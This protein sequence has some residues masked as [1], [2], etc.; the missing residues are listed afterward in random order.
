MELLELAIRKAKDLGASEAVASYGLSRRLRVELE[1]NDVKRAN[2]TVSRSVRVTV[3][4]GK[5]LATAVTTVPTR[6]EVEAIVDKAFKIAVASRPNEHWSGLPE[7]KPLPSVRGLYDER[8]AGLQAGEVVEMAIC[9]LDSAL[10]FDKRVSVSDGLVEVTVSEHGLATT[11]GF[12]GEERGTLIWGYISAVA[13]EAGEIGSFSFAID[14]SRSLD[15]DFAALGRRAA[16]LAV[17]S[18]GA[19]PVES[20]EGTL[21][22]DPDV[23]WDFFSTFSAAY[24]ASNVWKGSSPLA[25]RLGEQIAF[26]GLTVKDVGVLEGGTRSS[27]FDAEGSPRRE[28]V[29]IEHGVL[30]RYISN[31]YVG[32]ALGVEPTGNAATLLDVAPTNTVIEPGDMS[33][34]ELLEGVKRGIYI[35]RFSGDMRFQ[36]G[37]V[38]GVAKQAFYVENGEIVHPV[39]ECMVSANLYE[40]LKNISGLGKEVE[41]RL[42]VYTPAVRVERVKIVGK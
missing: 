33:F 19:K 29:I 28:T 40:M 36:D 31:T 20:F 10:S 3:I 35:R 26:E 14:A 38:S 8:L 16:K 18:L 1:N 37:V 6:E 13:K 17:E 25:G 32:N 5:R 12:R 27:L 34:E 39:K 23:A 11:T 15:V 7:P 24:N 30:K 9:A 42:D 4:I 2:Q 21:I 22:M 41:K